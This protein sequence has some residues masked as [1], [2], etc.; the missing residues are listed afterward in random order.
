M[1]FSQ[2]GSRKSSPLSP[3][4]AVTGHASAHCLRDASSTTVLSRLL[5]PSYHRFRDERAYPL[6]LDPCPSSTI[7]GP[8]RHN[9]Q[10]LTE[11]GKAERIPR[12]A[13]LLIQGC[14][15]KFEPLGQFEIGGIIEGETAPLGQT[16]RG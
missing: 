6:N 1:S 12:S 7:Q 16:Q 15:R 11:Q 8:R 10:S 13:Q 5:R 4:A 9:V 3:F 2:P 14:Q